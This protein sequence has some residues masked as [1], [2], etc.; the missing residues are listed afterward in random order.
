MFYTTMEKFRYIQ[1]K[2]DRCLEKNKLTCIITD[3]QRLISYAYKYNDVPLFSALQYP[4][5]G[6]RRHHR[7]GG[8]GKSVD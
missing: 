1:K 6:G 8:G 2:D 3:R 7:K 5:F 4:V